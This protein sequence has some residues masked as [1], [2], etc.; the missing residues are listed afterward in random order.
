MDVKVY[1]FTHDDS[2]NRRIKLNNP[3]AKINNDLLKDNKNDDF[4]KLYKQL[5]NI[6][7]STNLTV[8]ELCAL[9]NERQNRTSQKSDNNDESKY[10]IKKT[11]DIDK[12]SLY[13]NYVVDL[14]SYF[15][16]RNGITFNCPEIKIHKMI[17]ILQI[18]QAYKY[19]D[20]FDLNYQIEI[21]PCGFKIPNLAI[22]T[23][24]F[25]NNNYSNNEIDF[26]FEKKYLY[27]ENSGCFNNSLITNENKIKLFV[28]F[29]TFANSNP[30]V[31]G[32]FL[33]T[34]KTDTMK[35]E[36][37]NKISS[38]D[39]EELAIKGKEKME[40]F[41]GLNIFSFFKELKSTI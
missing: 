5:F 28:L 31:L 21:C 12:V 26:T 24:K 30:L 1:I 2:K 18:A 8:D 6:F 35:E 7:D 11:S 9:L 14:F 41:D 23:E 27:I 19:I 25:V 37:G 13:A 29:K 3:I 15:K 33:D 40:N 4:E 34:I 36:I 38:K 16:D 17:L 10:Y 32:Q 39:F 20:F 22:H